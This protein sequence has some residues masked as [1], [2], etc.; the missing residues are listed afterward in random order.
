MSN[1]VSQLSCTLTFF[2]RNV[3]SQTI[4]F[5][6]HCSPLKFCSEVHIVRVMDT[7]EIVEHA[8]RRNQQC[9]GFEVVLGTNA[10]ESKASLYHT[11][12]ALDH[13]TSLCMSKIEKLFEIRRP[14]ETIS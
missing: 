10:N 5:P 12:Y 3:M 2:C 8:N 7:D 11:K 4:R 13:I 9:L 14:G 1:V 6:P